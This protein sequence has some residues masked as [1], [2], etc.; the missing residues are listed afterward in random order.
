MAHW[1]IIEAAR[2]VIKMSNNQKQSS[3]S[4]ESSGPSADSN[5]KENGNE[6]T[7][8]SE[9]NKVE[10]DEKPFAEKN[11]AKMSEEELLESYRKKCGLIQSEID[12]GAERCSD[13]ESDNFELKA[14]IEE[15]R[16]MVTKS[17]ELKEGL[18]GMGIDIDKYLELIDE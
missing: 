18:E 13:L 2:L 4:S 7:T 5:Q 1:P 15:L 14:K 10:R 3:E 11:T 6:V 16:E 12:K 17:N 8:R 9:P